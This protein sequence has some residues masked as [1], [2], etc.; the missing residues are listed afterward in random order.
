MPLGSA[1]STAEMG[2]EPEKQ[3]EKGA[4]EQAGNDGKVESGVFAAMDDVAGQSSKTKGKLAAKVEESADE[5]EQPTQEEEGAAEFAERFHDW[6][7]PEAA[8]RQPKQIAYYD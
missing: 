5:R 3:R 8:G 6:I 7:L 4:E 2:E 1:E